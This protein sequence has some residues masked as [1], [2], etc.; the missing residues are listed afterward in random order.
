MNSDFRAQAMFWHNLGFRVIPG[1]PSDKVPYVS[2]KKYQTEPVTIR[3]INDWSDLF[4]DATPLLLTGVSN[5]E[6]MALYVIDVD[7]MSLLPWVQYMLGDSP[8][9]V[10]TGREGG[11]VH[12]YFQGEPQLIGNKHGQVGPDFSFEEKGNGHLQSSIDIKGF[13]GYVVAPG[14]FHK[15]G[16]QYLPQGID[17][18]S[19]DSDFLMGLPYFPELEVDDAL[20]SYYELKAEKRGHSMASECDVESWDDDTQV[21]LADGSTMALR[22][23]A[24]VVPVGS[25]K[26]CYCPFHE[27]KNSPSAAVYNSDGKISIHCFAEG[28]T[29]F[30]SKKT[31]AAS[32][33]FVDT[34]S[35]NTKNISKKYLQN[36]KAYCPELSKE[37][38]FIVNVYPMGHGKTYALRRLAASYEQVIAVGPTEAL[39]AAL[40]EGLGLDCYNDFQGDIVSKK[41]AVCAPSLCRI[42]ETIGGKPR[43]GH[44]LALDECDQLFNMLHDADI[45]TIPGTSERNTVQ[46]YNRL[47]Y[48]VQSAAQ[49]VMNDAYAS[50]RVLREIE[51]L[52]GKKVEVKMICPPEDYKPQLGWTE[53]QLSSK[54]ALV[55]LVE[56]AALAGD[57]GVV[58]CDTRRDVE[59]FTG[60]LQ[61]L[62]GA[63]HVLAIHS[64]SSASDK[65][66][67]RN[68]TEECSKY[69]WVV[70]N[71]AMGSGVSLEMEG[72]KSFLCFT[73]HIGSDGAQ[74]AQ[75]SGRLR[76]P[77]GLTRYSFVNPVEY[78]LEC[79]LDKIK[80]EEKKRVAEHY[81]A[82]KHIFQDGDRVAVY[83]D[84]EVLE[85]AADAV[86][87]KNTHTVNSRQWYYDALVFAGVELRKVFFDQ[88]E[89]DGYARLLN[90]IT[91][92]INA[93]EAEAVRLA[94]AT[95]REEAQELSSSDKREDV[96]MAKRHWSLEKWGAMGLQDEFINDSNDKLWSKCKLAVDT[97]LVFAGKQNVILERSKKVAYDEKTNTFIK[98]HLPKT[99]MQALV[100][101]EL[102][103]A[104]GWTEAQG[105]DW[106]LEDFKL[107]S[108]TCNEMVLLKV[109]NLDLKYGVKTLLAITPPDSV[110]KLPS[111]YSRIFKKIGLVTRQ[112]SVRT[113]DGVAKVRAVDFDKLQDWKKAT[114]RRLQKLL[115]AEVEK[116]EAL[117]TNERW[118]GL[119]ARSE[120]FVELERLNQVSEQTNIKEKVQC[121]F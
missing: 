86:W 31:F 94:P 24:K 17:L 57:K 112:K 78:D 87:Y 70:H 110:E 28:K 12:L 62:L 54:A 29:F 84:E 114:D 85:S 71:Q 1:K 16:R 103:R 53:Y 58:G 95:S 22:D 52:V 21:T 117:D 34:F 88:E 25:Y 50:P 77:V 37:D 72:Y 27:N 55:K 80:I 63:E 106:D 115:G 44:L 5:H 96:L 100:L 10:S 19:V 18:G 108:E 61:G 41:V 105:F 48:L 39:T 91:E 9:K 51:R 101:A 118:E 23:A 49:V 102:L 7:D 14:A 45:M 111:F 93:S 116:V 65:A 81:R 36:G 73:S 113:A 79:D 3:D 40:A 76:N 69:K 107:D 46:V 47:Q 11:G 67:L 97:R 43:H 75:I 74:L 8:L 89:V 42:K 99:D 60:L 68:A 66:K 15:S 119:R 121:P 32:T 120:L 64:G 104:L 33:L 13:G 83:K 30:P 26:T 38:R 6:D 59:A 82:V 35:H 98:A 4:Q 90:L 20:Q 56:E 109:Q 92:E 2:W